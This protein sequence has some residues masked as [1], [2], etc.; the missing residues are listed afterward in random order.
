MGSLID[1]AGAVGA[2]GGAGR[3]VDPGR[4]FRGL[5]VLP[6]VALLL[7]AIPLVTR[8][9]GDSPSQSA[10]AVGGSFEALVDDD[11]DASTEPVREFAGATRYETSLAAAQRYVATARSAGRPATIVIVA[12]GESLIDAAAA[13]GLAKTENAPV[14]LTRSAELFAPAAEFIEREGITKVLVMGGPE[15][16]S[17]AVFAA[18]R[19]INNV[20]HVIRVGGEN[21]FDTAALIAMRIAARTS[22][23]AQYCGSSEKAAVLVV[24]DG[25]S[26][27]DVT[28]AGP[29]SYS[30]DLPI[31]LTSTGGVP[32]ETAALLET[33]GIEHVVVV[34]GDDAVPAALEEL[35]V[36][37]VTRLAGANTIATS[38]VVL[39]AL[40]EC[41]GDAFDAT[42]IALISES[43]LPD[44]ISAAPMLGQGLKEF[45]QVTPVLLVR[46]TDLPVEVRNYLFTTDV[47]VVVTAI[48]GVNAVAASVSSNAVE[49]ANITTRIRRPVSGTSTTTLPGGVFSLPAGIEA[50]LGTT[51]PIRRSTECGVDAIQATPKIDSTTNTITIAWVITLA[52]LDSITLDQLDTL[53]LTLDDDQRLFY[54]PVPT[55]GTS[56]FD[57]LP[58]SAGLVKFTIGFKNSQHD[59]VEIGQLTLPAFTPATTTTVAPTLVAPTDFILNQEISLGTPTQCATTLFVHTEIDTT[60]NIILVRWIPTATAFTNESD[61]VTITLDDR[62]SHRTYSST[63]GYSRSVYFDLLPTSV[64]LVKFVFTFTDGREDCVERGQLPLPTY[65]PATT[66]TTTTLAPGSLAP[67]TPLLEGVPN[68]FGNTVHCG[69]RAIQTNPMIDTTTNTVKLFWN[70]VLDGRTAVRAAFVSVTLTFDGGQAVVLSI[71][72][73]PSRLEVDTF[74]ILPD[75]VGLLKWAFTFTAASGLA[76]CEERGQL[77]LPP[78]MPVAATALPADTATTFGNVGQC[79]VNVFTANPTIDSTTNIITVVWSVDPAVLTNS[80]TVTLTLDDG[81]SQTYD[82]VPTTDTTTTFNFL[83]TS[84]GLVKWV[85]TFTAASGKADCEES[86]QLTLPAFTP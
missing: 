60:T 83:S 71:S 18:L 63:L 47:A 59:C 24:G 85:V 64:G 78:Y 81:Q 46:S 32:A 45:G 16:V 35:G 76:D 15:A 44:G 50:T 51:A 20:E 8:G 48:G 14:L 2:V 38:V 55:S 62:Q 56:T 80:D 43:A 66:T 77:N 67:P 53:T 12:S 1:N 75:S 69:I 6:V 65:V 28:V 49:A 22:T 23:T 79:G 31:L 5:L 26:F 74:N 17:D 19:A 13:A 40:E 52:N 84:V 25:E 4:P 70:P 37:T 58:D 7:V 68:I 36:A 42:S 9:G 61:S 29:L 82:P 10:G 39:E 33:Q 41:L 30:M 57:I 21:R 72:P 27:A 3:N 73:L 86:G 34:G 54:D 11:G